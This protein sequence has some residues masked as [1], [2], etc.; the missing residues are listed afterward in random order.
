MNQ[1]NVFVLCLFVLT[2]HS[3][4]QK[5]FLSK[6]DYGFGIA[7]SFGTSL[8][9]F[10]KDFN[11]ADIFESNPENKIKNSGFYNMF[12]YEHDIIFSKEFLSCWGLS[13][14]VGYSHLGLGIDFNRNNYW[15]LVGARYE[16]SSYTVQ[17]KTY[18]NRDITTRLRFSIGCG[19]KVYVCDKLHTSEYFDYRGGYKPTPDIDKFYDCDMGWLSGNLDIGLSYRLNDRWN[20]FSVIYYE[21]ILYETEYSAE[22][23]SHS[24]KKYYYDSSYLIKSS[25][26]YAKITPNSFGISIGIEYKI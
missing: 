18:F 7:Y 2:I 21:K 14:G 19:T 8:S 17:L 1:V 13:L 25:F 3:Y 9:V 6:S 12:S 26:P 16:L 4:G 5:D 20:V 15:K 11:S 24:D 22:P 23:V 10:D